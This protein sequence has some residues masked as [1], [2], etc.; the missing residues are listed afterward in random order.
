MT[1]T[2]DPF[3]PPASPAATAG[4]QRAE[5]RVPKDH[6]RRYLLPDPTTGE[7]IPWRRVSTLKKTLA[8]EYGLNRWYQRQVAR[9]MALRDDLVALAAS[10]PD[11]KSDQGKETL[12]NVV[13]QAQDAAGSR[14]GANL[15]TALHS[16]TER[17]DRG[18]PLGSIV[19]PA[20][21][22]YDLAVYDRFKRANPE[23]L[24]T[25]P[26]HIERVL[27]V[28]ELQVAGTFDRLY[29][30]KVG[31]LKTGQNA[32][33]YGQ[34][35]LAVQLAC[36]AHG[37]LW[38]NLDTQEYE[39]VPEVDQTEAL[40]VHLPA[41]GNGKIDVFRVNI[42]AGWVAA[43][44]AYQ[45]LA[46]RSAQR[47]LVAPYEN[48]QRNPLDTLTA[49]ARQYPGHPANIGP[50]AGQQ[51]AASPQQTIE[52]KIDAAF[53]VESVP[54]PVAPPGA[55]SDHLD[56]TTLHPEFV[57]TVTAVLEGIPGPIRRAIL[58]ARSQ[59]QLAALY[60]QGSAA[61]MWT[62]AMTDLGFAVTAAYVNPCEITKEPHGGTVACGCGY[63]RPDLLLVS[64]KEF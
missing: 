35:E 63:R 38:W 11:P 16:A 47:T 27:V 55:V 23:L 30:N 29:G 5:D 26:A 45:V 13:K 31:D 10:V 57:A 50:A 8:D 3:A 59:E 61:G 46:M 14:K 64:I 4:S 28:P 51:L 37:A 40:M 12:G 15:G 62:Q 21:Y 24:R 60:A 33:E 53:P 36:Y 32:H 20:P 43:Q 2:R 34:L 58:D 52:Q 48:V 9:G 22:N 44:V 19:L 56:G 17:L 7:T 42:A 6:K 1:T 25:N 39:P 54:V 18:E 41:A 49:D